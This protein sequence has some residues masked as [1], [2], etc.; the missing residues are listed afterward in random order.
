[1]KFIIEDDNGKQKELGELTEAI[2]NG[3][4]IVKLNS[5]YRK[6]DLNRIHKDLSE[7]FGRNVIVLDARVDKIYVLPQ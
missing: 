7:Q 2:G 6:D 3:G 5:I 1:M 4:I